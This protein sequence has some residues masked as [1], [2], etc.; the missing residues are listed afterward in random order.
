VNKMKKILA[1]F[2]MFLLF[3][4]PVA[5]SAID[6]LTK[7]L[8][9]STALIIELAEDNKIL[10]KENSDLQAERDALLETSDD[11]DLSNLLECVAALEESTDLIFE[12]KERIEED[13]VEIERLRKIIRDIIPDID[14]FKMVELGIGGTYPWGGKVLIGFNIPSTQ[15]GIFADCAVF[16]NSGVLQVLVGV[17]IKFRF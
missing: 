1:I 17:G 13:Q 14:N 4:L 15:V 9:E 12:L 10:T 6:E 11:Q 7:Q 16:S 2:F 5:A 8:E 3:S